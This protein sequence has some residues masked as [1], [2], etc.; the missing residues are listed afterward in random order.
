MS[1]WSRCNAERQPA[2]TETATGSDESRH[3]WTVWA[4]RYL[5]KSKPFGA[6]N[7]ENTMAPAILERRPPRWVDLNYL[8]ASVNFLRSTQILTLPLRL[9]T[10]IIGA[11]QSV[12]W[13]TSAFNAFFQHTVEFFFHCR[14]QREWNF[15]CIVNTARLSYI[16]ELNLALSWLDQCQQTCL[17]RLDKTHL[18][19]CVTA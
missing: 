13:V 15:P 6:S 7:F 14:E 8:T 4:Q 17:N 11:H 2:E 3:P 19:S 12:G 1:Y 9:I 5:P 18:T 10:G 16:G